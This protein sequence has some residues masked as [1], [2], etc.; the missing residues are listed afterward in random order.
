MQTSNKLDAILRPITN[1]SLFRPANWF[2][3]WFCHI[4]SNKK[5]ISSLTLG[6]A[7]RPCWGCAD[8]RTAISWPTSWCRTARCLL[9][10]CCP[11]RTPHEKIILVVSERSRN[12]MEWNEWVKRPGCCALLQILHWRVSAK[13]PL[14]FFMLAPSWRREASITVPFLGWRHLGPMLEQEMREE[15]HDDFIC[16]RCRKRFAIWHEQTIFFNY[17][18]TIYT[19]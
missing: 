19:V 13:L 4:S 10:A 8:G 17:L 1:A 7:L 12:G 5:D 6:W 14:V 2:C 18:H 15:C 3:H 16:K 9:Q 11:Y